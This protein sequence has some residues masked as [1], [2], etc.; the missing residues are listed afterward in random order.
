MM[1]SA[2]DMSVEDQYAL[3]ATEEPNEQNVDEKLVSITEFRDHEHA[4]T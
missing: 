2:K 1:A 3:L 4:T